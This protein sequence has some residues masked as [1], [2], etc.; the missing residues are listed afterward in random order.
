M[1]EE[2]LAWNSVYLGDAQGEV[3]QT[4]KGTTMQGFALQ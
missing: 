4:G 3:G 2:E 1:K